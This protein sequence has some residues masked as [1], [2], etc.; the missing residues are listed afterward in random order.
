MNLNFILTFYVRKYSKLTKNI[1][2]KKNSGKLSNTKPK[3]LRLNFNLNKTSKKRYRNYVTKSA[4]SALTL[5]FLKRLKRT[6]T[7]TKKKKLTKQLELK[8]LKKK[9]SRLKRS[10]FIEKKQP[11]DF[12]RIKVLLG[13]TRTKKKQTVRNLIVKKF[14]LVSPTTHLD[15]AKAK[16]TSNK[17]KFFFLYYYLF[18]I[19]NFSFK[20]VPHFSNNLRKMEMLKS[21]TV[22]HS[23]RLLTLNPLFPTIFQQRSKYFCKIKRLLVWLRKRYSRFLYFKLRKTANLFFRNLAVNRFRFIN[24]KYEVPNN[25]KHKK[26][27]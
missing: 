24:I 6:N 2:Q 5:L 19:L 13:L 8:I 27:T 7:L 12:Y 3:S 18:K 22:L 9:F 1:L 14:N 4:K 21:L 15:T 10:T 26:L 17:Y 20:M 11:Q 25:K 23:S 16:V